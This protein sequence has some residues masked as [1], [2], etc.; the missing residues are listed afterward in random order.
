[1]RKVTIGYIFNEPYLRKDEKIFLDVAKK[2]GINLL[3]FNT[4][5]D[6][7]EETFE[8]EEKIKKCD[9]FF[10]NS[11]EDFALEIV[12]TIEELGKRVIESSKEFYY[13]E[14]K[15][16]FFLKC[17]EHKIPT[18]RT[19]L[20]SQNWNIIKKEL[21]GF[22]EW[23]VIL[24]RVEGTNG[25]YV[26]KAENL[27]EAEKIV[28]KFW[29]KGSDRLPIIA[30]EFIRSPSYR[31]TVIGNKVAQTAIKDSK[32][33]KATGVYLEDKNVGKFKVD[34]EI[35]K[36]IEKLNK[37]FKMKV[38]GVDLFRKDGKWLVLEIN[39]APGLD[40]FNKEEKRL[41]GEILDFLKKE[42]INRRY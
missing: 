6:L 33:W 29:K 4:A 14:D 22:N 40:F 25:N 36:I 31:I 12:K 2:K 41:V 42:V 21:Q 23:P 1:M 27:R 24:K 7:K 34:K 30:Q 32:G 5:K 20:L 8:F 18:L 11:A 13:D 19:I 9:I 39:S 16:M 35:K 37:T 17:K 28:N 15:W 3:M 10:N 26:D 38:Y